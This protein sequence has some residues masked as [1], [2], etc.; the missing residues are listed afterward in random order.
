MLAAWA[1]VIVL[2]LVSWPFGVLQTLSRMI[3]E[4]MLLELLRPPVKVEATAQACVSDEL[5]SGGSE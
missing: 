2:V 4:G 1:V 3:L 5:I